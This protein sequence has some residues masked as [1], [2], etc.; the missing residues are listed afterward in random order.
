LE[1]IAQGKIDW[2]D[3]TGELVYSVN[4]LA[5]AHFLRDLSRNTTRGLLA[6]AREG[7]AG[8][9]GSS[10]YGYRSRKNELTKENEVWV[11]PEE[12]EIVRLIFR[13]FLAPG[14][15]L[16]GVAAE[17]N[18]RGIAPPEAKAWRG[19][20]VRVILTRRKYTGCFI[21]GRKNEGKYFC[22]RDGEIIPRRKS[23]R[24]VAADPI[25]IPDRFEAIVD[26]ETFDA[27]QRKLAGNRTKTARRTARQYVLAGLLKCGDCKRSMGGLHR[28]S[29]AIYRCRLFH[30]SGRIVCYHNVITIRARQPSRFRPVLPSFLFGFELRESWRG[31]VLAD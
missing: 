12:A 31:G 2:E 28:H 6:A 25:V 11:V 8:T 27:A 30:Q 10:P 1:T 19:S 13:L 24:S 15:S 5:K 26:Q 22:L 16:R 14:G 29:G 21:H 9:G 20:S 4:Q 18:R 23:D 3:L 7:R 17:L